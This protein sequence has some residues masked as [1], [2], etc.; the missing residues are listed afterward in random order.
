MQG[1]IRTTSSVMTRTR[2]IVPCAPVISQ[3]LRLGM[4]MWEASV[5]Y[6]SLWLRIVNNRVGARGRLAISSIKIASRSTVMWCVGSS[7]SRNRRLSVILVM[8]I[9]V[10]VIR[11]ICRRSSHSS[12]VGRTNVPVIVMV[13]LFLCQSYAAGSNCTKF[14]IMRFVVL[15]TP[16]RRLLAG[17]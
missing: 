14:S 6:R 17:T 15:A 3:L 16:E 9:S 5:V 10:S 13:V 4:G 1:Y 11:S 2:S 12:V 8:Y 7:D